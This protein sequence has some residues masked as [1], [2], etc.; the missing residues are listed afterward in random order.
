MVVIAEKIEAEIA[1]QSEQPDD[2]DLYGGLTLE[3]FAETAR[4]L[5]RAYAMVR[6]IDFLL[7]SDDTEETFRERWEEVPLDMGAAKAERDTIVSATGQWRLVLLAAREQSDRAV[8]V[9]DSFNARAQYLN[10]EINNGRIVG[11]EDA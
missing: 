8:S 11:A 9:I 5:R 10:E 1:L 7:S 4:T 3:R 6:R 2:I